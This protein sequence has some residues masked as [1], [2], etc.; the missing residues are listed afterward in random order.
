[1][2]SEEKVAWPILVIIVVWNMTIE[3][4]EQAINCLVKCQKKSPVN[5]LIPVDSFT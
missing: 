4:V 5:V 1:M 3:L 2:F